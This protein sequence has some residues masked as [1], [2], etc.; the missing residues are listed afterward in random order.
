MLRIRGGW[1]FSMWGW[2]RGVDNQSAIAYKT[3]IFY[4]F[5][6]EKAINTRSQ[7]SSETAQRGGC[8]PLNPPP[9]CVFWRLLKILK[10]KF[11][12]LSCSEW[13]KNAP[14]SGGASPCREETIEVS[15]S[16]CVTWPAVRIEQERLAI[17]RCRDS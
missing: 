7:T 17:I 3:T 11:P 6:E 9:Y 13:V 14:L 15:Q 8:K 4:Y 2:G 1:I 12:T 10:K 16:N 5:C